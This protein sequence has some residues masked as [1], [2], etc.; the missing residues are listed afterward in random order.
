MSLSFGRVSY[1]CIHERWQNMIQALHYNPFL[2]QRF[3][4][5]VYMTVWL[6][7]FH[8][9]KAP[10]E[11]STFTSGDSLTSAWGGKAV[12]SLQHLLPEVIIGKTASRPIS[13]SLFLL[14]F[15]SQPRILQYCRMNVLYKPL[16]LL[17]KLVHH[18]TSSTFGTI[19]L[20]QRRL[21]ALSHLR[22]INKELNKL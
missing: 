8:L 18:R 1:H 7:F 11:A 19:I 5:G 21:L 12:I 14:I 15:T 17:D 20:K 13:T 16:V 4:T 2:L 3:I 22:C 6:I 10:V 9:A